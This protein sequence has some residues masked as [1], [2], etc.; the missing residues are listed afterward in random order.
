ME[1][2]K[3]IFFLSVVC[4]LVH[5]T[6][7]QKIILTP[8]WT[9]QAQF[10]GYYVAEQMGFYKEEGLDVQVK[11]PAV[12]ESSFS[13]L[14]EGR[15]QVAVMNLSFALTADADLVN[16]MQTSQENSLMLVSRLPLENINSLQH[17]KVAI[18]NHLSDE[19]L[20]RLKRYYH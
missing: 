6:E 1:W 19:L 3:S 10:I 12:S 4:L 20:D 14:Q 8:K 17:K 18:W 5:T 9:A 2:R 7:A 11:H 13:I 15:S 16:V